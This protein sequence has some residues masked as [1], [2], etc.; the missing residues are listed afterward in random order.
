MKMNQLFQ[1]HDR[2]NDK[3]AHIGTD[4]APYHAQEPIEDDD[5]R[6]AM[7]Q[8]LCLHQYLNELPIRRFEKTEQYRTSDRTRKRCTTSEDAH[9]EAWFDHCRSVFPQSVR[10]AGP[11]VDFHNVPVQHRLQQHGFLQ[12]REWIS[13]S[14]EYWW[15]DFFIRKVQRYQQSSVVTSQKILVKQ[16]R[17]CDLDVRG[18][19][20]LPTDAKELLNDY[21]SVGCHSSGIRWWQKWTCRNLWNQIWQD[22]R[23]SSQGIARAIFWAALYWSRVCCIRCGRQRRRHKWRS[24]WAY[25]KMHQWHKEEATGNQICLLRLTCCV[26]HLHHKWAMN[27]LAA[28][29]D[30]FKTVLQQVCHFKVDVIAGDAKAAAHK[31]YKKQERQDLHDSSVAVMPLIIL[32]III[33]LSFTQQ[34]ILIVALWHFFMEK[35]SRTPNHEKSLEQSQ[36]ESFHAFSWTASEQT[37]HG[38]KERK[39]FRASEESNLS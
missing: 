30:F 15:A 39:I 32:P 20:S 5:E 33:R 24:L 14:W 22:V 37:N 25:S 18:C 21:G 28:V 27:S 13:E 4:R 19:D 7:R 11:E 38:E 34:M 3:K 35:A 26:C 2:V 31:Y 16:R 17:A 12:Q 1:G 9:T 6:F 8:G 29:T 23:K 36:N 10:S